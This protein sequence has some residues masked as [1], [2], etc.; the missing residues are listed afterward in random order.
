MVA[1]L[2]R[3][4]VLGGGVALG[5]AAVLG[6][7]AQP[8][9]AAAGP[10][11][12]V[13]GPARVGATFGLYPFQ[14]KITNYASAAA[15][16]NTTTG[17]KMSCWKLYYQNSKFPTSP[18]PQM[19]VMIKQ[20]IQALISFKPT[21]LINAAQGRNDRAKLADAV[22]MLK[23]NKLLGEICLWQEVG[24]KD[25]E[26]GQYQDLVA[27]YEPVIRPHYPLVFDAS[28]YQGY[29]EWVAYKPDDSLLDGYALD[30]YC[31]DFINHGITLDQFMPLAGEK[32][33]GVWEIGNS[34]SKKFTPTKTDV[35]KY[36]DHIIISLTA[37]LLSGLPVGSVAWYDGP[38]VPSKSGGNGINEIVGTHPCALAPVDIALYR[39]LYAAVNGRLPIIITA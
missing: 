4:A 11:K 20:G 10:M 27:F 37:R 8:A 26:P 25:M 7:R 21:P 13:Y 34:A 38:A 19:V 9:A 32:P 24:P 18:E 23:E 6:A 3:R 16:W 31:S 17:T 33:V 22:A 39:Q 12:R 35:T 1:N 14:P 15:D 5:A 28:G 30:F 36:M 29:R 2:S